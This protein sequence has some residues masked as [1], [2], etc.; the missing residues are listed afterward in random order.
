MKSGVAAD[1]GECP[2]EAGTLPFFI[3]APRLLI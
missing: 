2:G 3:P 1:F